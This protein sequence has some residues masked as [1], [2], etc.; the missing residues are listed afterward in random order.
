LAS[1]HQQTQI[2][3]LEQTT[4]GI[5]HEL[6]EVLPLDQ[7]QRFPPV[8]SRWLMQVMVVDQFAFQ[9]RV[10]VYSDLSLHVEESPTLR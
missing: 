6:Q 2:C 9:Q 10:A 8:L 7:Q 5:T 1:D 3:I 4:L